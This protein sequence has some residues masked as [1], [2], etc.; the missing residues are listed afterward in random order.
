M[1]VHGWGTGVKKGWGEGAVMLSIGRLM[2]PAV[3]MRR[4][5]RGGAHGR[6]QQGKE[7]RNV[8]V[9]EGGD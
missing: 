7:A 3:V 2:F 4:A 9:K 6:R 5:S 8:G 1:G